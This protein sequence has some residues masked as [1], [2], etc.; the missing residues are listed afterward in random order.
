[1]AKDFPKARCRF[2]GR[3]T[4]H[5]NKGILYHNNKLHEEKCRYRKMIEDSDKEETVEEMLE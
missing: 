3:I 4:W 1:M 5:I 2:C